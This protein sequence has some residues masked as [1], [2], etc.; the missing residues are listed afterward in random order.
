MRLRGSEAPT[1]HICEYEKC[2]AKEMRILIQKCAA[3][4][5]GNQYFFD[6]IYK[7]LNCSL[8]RRVFFKN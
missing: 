2:R 5:Y 7:A 3:K 4:R 8:G 1:E 6:I